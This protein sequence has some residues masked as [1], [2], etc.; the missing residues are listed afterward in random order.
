ME[1]M[2]EAKFCKYD[3]ERE[4]KDTF[5]RA[6]FKCP[7]LHPTHP[8][9]SYDIHDRQ[10]APRKEVDYMKDD[11]NFDWS[12]EAEELADQNPS[13]TEL[14][15]EI[16][17][18]EKVVQTMTESSDIARPRL[19][20]PESLCPSTHHLN[21][22]GLPCVLTSSTPPEV[23]GWFALRQPWLKK[24]GHGV[25][26]RRVTVGQATRYIDPVCWFGGDM[27]DVEQSGTELC[28]NL[29]A[30]IR[31]AYLPLGSWTTDEYQE[32]EVPPIPMA[33][34]EQGLW[35]SNTLR[36]LPSP[37]TGAECDY[38]IVINDDGRVHPPR[39][40]QYWQGYVPSKLCVVEDDGTEDPPLWHY[41]DV[42]MEDAPPVED[43]EP[44]KERSPF[45]VLDWT[46]KDIQSLEDDIEGLFDDGNPPNVDEGTPSV[47]ESPV[48]REALTDESSETGL[49]DDSDQDSPCSEDGRVVSATESPV[50]D[51]DASDIS[52]ETELDDFFYKDDPRDVDDRLE[53]TT[54][55]LITDEEVSDEQSETDLNDYFYQEGLY[56]LG[57]SVGIA[58]ELPSPDKESICEFSDDET[59][60]SSSREALYAVDR[61]QAPATKPPTLDE[62]LND[63]ST[64]DE[65]KYRCDRDSSCITV[66]QAELTTETSSPVENLYSETELR[67]FSC[68]DDSSKGNGN[69]GLITEPLIFDEESIYDFSQD[70]IWESFDYGD[71]GVEDEKAVSTTDLD[72]GSN[73]E[74]S[75]DAMLQHPYSQSMKDCLDQDDACLEDEKAMFPTEPLLLEEGLS[76]KV[77]V[78][79][80]LETSFP[81]SSKECMA[82]DGNEEHKSPNDNTHDDHLDSQSLTDGSV[83][84]DDALSMTASI[85]DLF[86]D[87]I[88]SEEPDKDTQHG[89]RQD[90]KSGS[91]D[92][93]GQ[94]SSDRDR[95]DSSISNRSLLME[96]FEESFGKDTLTS[97]EESE[98]SVD[99]ASY[100]GDAADNTISNSS[101]IR[102][103]FEELMHNE[104]LAPIEDGPNSPEPVVDDITTLNVNYNM[105]EKGMLPEISTHEAEVENFSSDGLALYQ[106]SNEILIR[107]IAKVAVQAFR[108]W[109]W[110][111]AE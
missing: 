10:S 74:M 93:I 65:M 76:E 80:M 24:I 55:L 109:T 2:F 98:E 4:E 85:Y 57:D 48:F 59:A 20:Q 45:V 84:D 35:N 56:A 111:N 110:S 49:N 9:H 25:N 87:D 53:P 86:Y 58:T 44:E 1:T 95:S 31:K 77:S 102:Y 17:Y 11:G 60:D 61:L 64:P 40:S 81:E 96:A 75:D 101:L 83:I 71:F 108:R 38:E 13:P 82:D 12:D 33:A 8:L 27:I 100:K 42:E 97:A 21:F 28:T 70:E 69:A 18:N 46:Q 103:A 88:V 106:E 6:I 15:Y 78:H 68:Q 34:T 62:G 67:N 3:Y 89:Q 107:S 63:I 79:V 39:T 90:S 92:S 47:A 37:C 50:F 54:K 91:G 14:E 43:S 19:L 52:S 23:S 5:V 51:E 22:Q 7:S 104:E 99:C 26:R 36:S 30:S 32:S 66:D 72:A 105:E 73:D 16:V 94:T 41:N 29:K